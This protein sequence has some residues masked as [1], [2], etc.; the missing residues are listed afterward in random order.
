MFEDACAIPVD[1]RK[2][3]DL[4]ACSALVGLS[5]FTTG[6]LFQKKQLKTFHPPPP[7]PSPTANLKVPPVADPPSLVILPEGSAPGIA[8]NEIAMTG[9][10]IIEF[11]PPPPP[12]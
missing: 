6:C 3:V 4:W 12:A 5:L 2:G 10:G 8:S 7:K 9:P 1:R 11:P